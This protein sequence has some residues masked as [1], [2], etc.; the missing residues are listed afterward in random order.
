MQ[1]NHLPCVFLITP[2]HALR[3]LWTPVLGFWETFFR[4]VCQVKVDGDGCVE[5]TGGWAAVLFAFFF[6]D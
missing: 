5:V 1:S 4:A 2:L 3:F 6:T